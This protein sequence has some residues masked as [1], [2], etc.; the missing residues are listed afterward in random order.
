MFIKYKEGFE[1][2]YELVNSV[3]SKLPNENDV[4]F[5][6]KISKKDEAEILLNKIENLY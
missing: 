1:E 5:D 6:K 4:L 3:G 2:Y